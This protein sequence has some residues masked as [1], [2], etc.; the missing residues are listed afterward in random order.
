MAAK[1]KYT[2][3]GCPAL[4]CS[5]LEE[6]ITRPNSREEVDNLKWELHFSNTKV[7]IRNSR[8]YKLTM[9]VCRYLDENNLCSIY[10]D[11]PQVCRDHNPPSCEYYGPIYDVMFESPED[12]QAHIDKEKR[13]KKRKRK[14]AK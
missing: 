10:E 13:R 7:F 5:D 2:C 11:R 9:G 3:E 12:L 1:T 14:R 6:P 8:W 4:C